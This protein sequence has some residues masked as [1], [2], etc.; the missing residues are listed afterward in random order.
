MRQMSAPAPRSVPQNAAISSSQWTSIGPQ[1]INTYSQLNSGRVWALA[2][3]PGNTAVVY[4]GTDGGGVWKTTN[5][6][7]AW[8]P[9]TDQQ[10]SLGISS[11]ALDPSNSATIYA[12]TG[13]SAA[14]AAGILKS[15]D[16]GDT[17]TQITG[18]FVPPDFNATISAIAV[19]SSDDQIVLAGA[20]GLGVYRSTDGGTTWTSVPTSTNNYGQVLEVFFDPSNPTTAYASVEGQGVYKSADTGRSWSP[21]NGSGSNSLPIASMGLIDI[22]IAPSAPGTIYAALK[23][24][25]TGLLLGFYKTTDG[26]ATWRSIAA[27][28]GDNINYWGWSLRVHPTNPNVVFAGSLL[29]SSDFSSCV[30]R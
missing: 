11:L 21:I 3:D 1:P 28:P 9:L 23:T 29:L 27:P 22:A 4:A 19:N 5:G 17:W 16:A 24:N 30:P 7:A 15:T 18:P 6:G 8:T 25:T 26:G 2:V 13:G 20:Q 14:Y 10:A 12:G